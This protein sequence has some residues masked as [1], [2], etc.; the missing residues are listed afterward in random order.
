MNAP[1]DRSPGK[2]LFS[3]FPPVPTAAWETQIHKDLKGTDYL[4]KLSWH[5]PD[6]LTLRPFY[7]REDL[8]GLDHLRAAPGCPPF[9]RGTHATPEAVRLAVTIVHDDL[10]EANRLARTL[11]SDPA[12][13]VEVHLPLEVRDDRLHGVPV[14]KQDDLARLLD[15]LP[16]DA[17]PLHV[18]GASTALPLLAMWLNLAEAQGLDVG[19]L[20]GTF[21]FDPLSPFERFG[22]LHGAGAVEHTAR[23]LAATAAR[24]PGLR[25]LACDAVR[26]HEAGATSVQVLA[27]TLGA[28]SDLLARLS[29]RGL[30]PETILD[31]L[32]V[33]MPLDVH[34]FLSVA[35]FR[36]F[37]LLFARLVEAYTGSPPEPA[38]GPARPFVVARVSRSHHTRYDPYVNMLRATTGAAAAFVGGCDVLC[39]EPHDALDG[40]SDTFGHRIALNTGRILHHEAHLDRVI[41]PAGGSYYLE[42]LTDRLAEAAWKRFRTLEAEGGLLEALRRGTVQREIATRRQRRDQEVVLRRAVLVGVNQYPDLDERILDR[43]ERAAPGHPLTP[44][45]HRPDAPDLD[46]LRRALREGTPLDALLPPT[47]GGTV[48]DADALCPHRGAEALERLRLRTERH[49]RMTGHLPTVFLLPFGEPAMRNA[50]ATFA[51]NFFGC[52][53]FSI[54][55]PPGWDDPLEGIE[56]A[57]GASPDLVVLCSTDDAYPAHTARIVERLRARGVAAPVVVAGHPEAHLDALR[58]AGV[59]AF[60]HRRSNLL[61]ALEHFQQK[62]GIE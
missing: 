38:N 47:P 52:A 53:G 13:V 5:T 23:L 16:L 35:R 29:D 6:G 33:T 60:I 44:A 7:R 21:G 45:K 54:V 22:W 62:L 39:L 8:E 12:D 36:A 43:V 24:A 30:S 37:R 4:D 46:T 59:D 1:P 9:V 15:G 34:F 42:T 49:A 17:T 56:A 48:P 57:A 55:A 18:S 20:Q 14:R 28:A 27:F 25:V 31:A 32:H 3:E 26:L 2:A 10:A 40:R 61:E 11:R 19:R 58:R 51:R 41:D 50:R